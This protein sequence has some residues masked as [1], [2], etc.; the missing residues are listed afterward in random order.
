MRTALFYGG[1]EIRVEEMPT[2]EPGPGEVLVRIGAAGIC[3]S[4]LHMYRGESPWGG[5][6]GDVPRRSGH[7]LSGTVAAV[8]PHVTGI[9]SVSA[10]ALSQHRSAAAMPILRARRLPSLLQPRPA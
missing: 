9:R 5:W 4:D 1:P 7:E 6:G 8:G 3:G 10:S 2:P